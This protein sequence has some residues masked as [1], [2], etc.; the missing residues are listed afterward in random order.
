VQAEIT[1]TE[2]ESNDG[3]GKTDICIYLN[4]LTEVNGT[5]WQDLKA[6]AMSADYFDSEDYIN[7]GTR[8]Q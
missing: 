7:L 2:D 8:D 6:T 4:D 5:D 1:W 3:T